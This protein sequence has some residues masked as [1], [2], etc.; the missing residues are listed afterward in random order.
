MDT[1]TKVDQLK[2]LPNYLKTTFSWNYNELC[3]GIKVLLITRKLNEIVNRLSY[4][5]LY[6]Q[7]FFN[8]FDVV[9]DERR[10]R[11]FKLLTLEQ[12][13]QALARDEDSLKL[14]CDIMQI[15]N[16]KWII[17]SL[18]NKVVLE[19]RCELVKILTEIDQLKELPQYLKINHVWDYTGFYQAIKVIILTHKLKEIVHR[20]DFGSLCPQNFFFLNLSDIKVSKEQ[21][22]RIFKLLTLEQIVKILAR[23]EDS[24][25]SN[26]FNIA[27]VIN[28]KEIVK[29]L[30][31]QV[32]KKFK[33]KTVE[34]LAEIEQ[35]S[36]LPE[37]P[38]TNTLESLVG[39]V[40]RSE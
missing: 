24:P 21:Q 38:V 4:D 35:L 36:E 29:R 5:S 14:D 6:P 20:L 3:K 30:C 16:K 10:Q 33:N 17:E 22:K 26:F 37:H 23:G 15:I 12:V 2:G 13:A 18:C 27:Q 1:L 25:T 34:I 8:V 19:F 7:N 31:D 28:K 9:S 39:Y 40:K 32:V 11:I